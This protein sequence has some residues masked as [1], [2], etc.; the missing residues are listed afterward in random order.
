MGPP[1]PSS[2]HGE[3]TNRLAAL[4]HDTAHLA[5]Y[6]TLSSAHDKRNI[7]SRQSR[8]AAHRARR[9]RCRRSGQDRRN[10]RQISPAPVRPDR[11]HGP[12]VVGCALRHL[13][14][15]HRPAAVGRRRRSLYRRRIPAGLSRLQ[16]HPAC[17][18]DG[19]PLFRS[20]RSRGRR[21]HR[22][23]AALATGSVA[24]SGPAAKTQKGAG[25]PLRPER[26][27][28]RRSAQPRHRRH[29]PSQGSRT[30][31]PDHPP[32]KRTDHRRR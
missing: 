11:R 2:P 3:A 5:P 15:C 12:P 7:C 22:H 24:G 26:R 29:Q 30:R 6:F 9:A 16:P 4:E 17:A 18:A 21:A 14:R 10:S 20:R 13:R 23:A 19:R 31:S 8:R 1:L 32:G 27:R 25:G 28:S